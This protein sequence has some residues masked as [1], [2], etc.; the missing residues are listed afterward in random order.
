MTVPPSLATLTAADFESRVGDTFRLQIPPQELAFKLVEVR[1]LGQ[2][3]R[4]GGAF[5][6]LFMT[7]PG[8]FLRQ[9]TYPLDNPSLGQLNLF[10]VPLGPKD[11]GNSYEVVFT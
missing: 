10:I 1:K 2:A 11:G 8:P 6:L 3:V 5:S 4:E 9:G 7:P